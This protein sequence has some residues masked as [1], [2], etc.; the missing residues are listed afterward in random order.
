LSNG[1]AQSGL[2]FF[3]TVADISAW[4][5]RLEAFSDGVLSIIT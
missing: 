3:V 2:S 4:K 1:A 5:N